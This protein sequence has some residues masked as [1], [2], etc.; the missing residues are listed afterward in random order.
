MTYFSG[1]AMWT[2]LS[3]PY[4]LTLPGVYTEQL[5]T[6][7][8]QGETWRRLGVQYPDTIATHSPKQVLYIDPD[9]LIRRRDPPS[10]SRRIRLPPI[11]RATFRQS[12]ASSYPPAGSSTAATQPGTA[13]KIRS[14]SRSTSTT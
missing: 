3:E 13:S 7:H 5:S 8:E 1:Y 4:S 14:W 2:Y 10:R 9:G 12:T 6:W 11:T